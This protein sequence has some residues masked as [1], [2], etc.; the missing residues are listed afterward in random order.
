M[1]NIA[2]DNGINGLVVHKTTHEEVT[3]NVVN[4][5][6]FDNGKTSKDVEGR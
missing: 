4:N 2:F 5:R 6:V 1:D 3:I